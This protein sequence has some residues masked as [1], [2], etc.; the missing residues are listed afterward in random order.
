[1]VER[2]AKRLPLFS[3]ITPSYNMLQFLPACCNSVSDQNVDYEHIV[4]DGLSIDG[5]VAWLKN[6]PNII[7]VSEK[8]D[9]MYDAV[10]NGVRIARGEIISYLNCDEQYLPGA[11]QRVE[12]FFQRNSKV[13]ILF[14]NALII[15]PNGKLLAYRKSFVPRWP[16]I[17]ASHMYTHSS[18]MFVRRNVFESGLFFDKDWKTVGDADFVVRVL[19]KGFIAHHLNEYFSA[20]MITGSNLGDS[21]SALVE[22]K[23]FRNKAP[24]WLRY[25]GF[26]TNN[27]IRLEKFW[28]GAYWE[29][30]PLFYSVYTTE[31]LDVRYEF[32]AKSVSPLYPYET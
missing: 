29:K 13:D 19:R 28:N 24:F 9:G 31:C 4:V 15:R 27:L 12:D 3:I 5:T 10:N 30:L 25:S 2:P 11:L 32:V 1:M 14:G 20:F 21:E 7:S 6:R 22:L 23:S 8:D 18:S 17:W 16:Y 26:I